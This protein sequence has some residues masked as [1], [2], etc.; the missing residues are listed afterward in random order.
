MLE[1]AGSW[2][3]VG[4][5]QWCALPDDDPAKLAALL[6]AAQHWALRMETC[7]AEQRCAKRWAECATRHAV[8]RK[9]LAEYQAGHAISAAADWTAISQQIRTRNEF[10][11]ERPWLKR[12]SA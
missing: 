5:P 8:I 4:S 7:Q 10:Y 6:D 1:A 3:L 2:P 11:T 9:K 12:A